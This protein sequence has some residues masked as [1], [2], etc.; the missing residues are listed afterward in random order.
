MS[1]TRIW[2]LHGMAGENEKGGKRIRVP[3][4]TAEG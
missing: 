1:A 4:W 2:K 3:A